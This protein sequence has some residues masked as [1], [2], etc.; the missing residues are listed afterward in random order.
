MDV[1]ERSGPG[2]GAGLFDAAKKLAMAAIAIAGSRALADGLLPV[3]GLDG[4]RLTRFWATIAREAYEK[5]KW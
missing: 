4:D 3:P 2:A 5:G 1:D